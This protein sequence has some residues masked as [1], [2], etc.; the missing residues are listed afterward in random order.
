MKEAQVEQK[1]L[2]TVQPIQ[3]AIVAIP[4]SPYVGLLADAIKTGQ[5]EIASKMMDLQE[6]WEDRQAEKAFVAALAAFKRNPPEIVKNKKV[7][8]QN[9]AGQT[10]EY[11]HATLDRVTGAIA[12]GL[13]EHGLS[14]DWETSQENGKIRVTCFLQHAFGHREKRASLEGPPDDSGAKNSVQ[15]IASTVTFLERYTLLAATGLATRDDADGITFGDAEDMLNSIQSAV[16]LDE[17]QERFNKAYKR[18]HMAK[19]KNAMAIAIEAKDRRKAELS[20]KVPKSQVAPENPEA[21]AKFD[22]FQALCARKGLN[23]ANRHMLLG[24]H[25]NIDAAIAELKGLPDPPD[26]G[27]G[28]PGTA[29]DLGKTPAHETKADPAKK[30]RGKRWNQADTGVRTEKPADSPAPKEPEWGF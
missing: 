19:D 13:G 9:K 24:K 2:V 25:D 3:D 16:S 17:L 26:V 28:D 11:K 15:A 27:Q 1:D 14:A 21:K 12:A 22:E 6:R 10:V 5:L 20:G 8:Y 18:A 4:P 29:G 23:E 30:G 7:S